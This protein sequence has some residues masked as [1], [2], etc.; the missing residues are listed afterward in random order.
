MYNAQGNLICVDQRPRKSQHDSLQ[1][2]FPDDCHG[3]CSRLPL[4][5]LSHSDGCGEP[6]LPNTVQT[7]RPIFKDLFLCDQLIQLCTP[8]MRVAI[9]EPVMMCPL[10]R[11]NRI[12]LYVT[13]VLDCRK[14]DG[15]RRPRLLRCGKDW[16]CRTSLRAWPMESLSIKC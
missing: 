2:R 12:D 10:N 3:Q 7:L 8:I 9:P 5:V 16:E 11:R 4:A 15:D 6:S 13:K 14:R 1:H